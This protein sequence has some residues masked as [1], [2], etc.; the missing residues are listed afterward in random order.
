M[1]PYLDNKASKNI[2][3]YSSYSVKLPKSAIEC[4]LYRVSNTE[5]GE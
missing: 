5:M 3:L 2:S 1:K 4:L